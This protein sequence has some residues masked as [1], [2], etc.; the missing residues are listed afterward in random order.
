M[1]CRE[2]RTSAHPIRLVVWQVV[3]VSLAWA[4]STLLPIAAAGEAVAT[5]R[6]PAARQGTDGRVHVAALRADGVLLP[7]ATFDGDDWASTWP[8][9]LTGREL[10]AG[11]P[12]IPRDWWR[13]AEPGPW[14]IYS[15]DSETPRVLKLLRPVTL[16]IGIGRRFGVLTDFSTPAD[17]APFEV[18][19]PK[20]GLAVSGDVDLKPLRGIS[21]L[22][23]VTRQLLD[24]LRPALN[25]AE[26][27][28]LN[29][30]RS[31]TGWRHPI[32]KP[33]RTRL[34]PE[35][36]AWYTA[37]LVNSDARVSYVEIAKKYPPGPQD[38]GCG[39]ETFI[40]GWVFHG[41]KPL[42]SPKSELRAKVLYCDRAQA[43]YILPFAQADIKDR[44]YWIYQMSGFDH[45][46]YV[47]AETGASRVRVQ[48][49]YFAGGY[50]AQLL[51]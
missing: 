14:R 51:R 39:L 16:R 9:D 27:R 33:F 29:A 8:A 25:D 50:P 37:P 7:F 38:E 49:E 2:G 30:L 31:N 5:A 12:S 44:T 43:S 41:G 20:A 34:V 35:V 46:W 28:T 24:A 1:R 21:R 10:P 15:P 36:E 23:P 17:V 47:V 40:T 45:E 42:A 3:S 22:A 13:G 48:A 18:P 4:A 11:I 6:A 32:D 26:E 19:F